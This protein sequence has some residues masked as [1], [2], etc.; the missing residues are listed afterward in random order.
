[1]AQRVNVKPQT[2]TKFQNTRE[3]CSENASSAS[4]HTQDVSARNN[5]DTASDGMENHVCYQ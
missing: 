4:G 2:R 5:D 1:M 3:V